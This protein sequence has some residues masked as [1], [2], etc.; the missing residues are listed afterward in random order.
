M[1]MRMRVGDG[2]RQDKARQ[3]YVGLEYLYRVQHESSRVQK[4][5]AHTV[6]V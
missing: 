6:S 3:K 5:T 4:S 1:W 2:E